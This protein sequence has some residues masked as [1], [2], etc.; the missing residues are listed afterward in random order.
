MTNLPF[1]STVS[2]REAV[3][4]PQVLKKRDAI[5]LAQHG[6]STVARR[7]SSNNCRLFCGICIRYKDDASPMVVINITFGGPSS[8][9]KIRLKLNP[10]AT[11][12]PPTPNTT[13]PRSRINSHESS[14]P[15]ITHC[16]T[17]RELASGAYFLAPD[18][19]FF[20]LNTKTLVSCGITGRIKTSQIKLIARIILYC[21]ST[22]TSSAKMS[23]T[24]SLMPLQRQLS[25][26]KQPRDGCSTLSLLK[27]QQHFRRSVPVINMHRSVA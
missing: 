25:I 21:K 6:A 12:V 3:G 11:S 1:I 13:S 20:I 9:S 22:L 19:N 24:M 16:L 8:R 7:Q 23:A 15:N 10:K 26:A 4:K 5:M 17:V 18:M 14:V 2:T 27:S